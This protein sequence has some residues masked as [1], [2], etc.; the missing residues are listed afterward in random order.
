M[1]SLSIP[2]DKSEHLPLDVDVINFMRDWCRQTI[3]RLNASGISTDRIILDAGIGFGKTAKQ[4][5]VLLSH[6]RD[7][8]PD[9]AAIFIGHS[10][11]SFLSLFT[12]APPTE[13]DALTRLVSAM[14]AEQGADYLRVHDVAGHRELLDALSA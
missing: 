13:R 1:H 7:W 2:A 14:L 6:L 3:D 12:D 10:R 4:S 8:A 9:D 5:W 11:K